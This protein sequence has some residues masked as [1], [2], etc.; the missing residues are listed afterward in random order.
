MDWQASTFFH[1]YTTHGS[2]TS[3]ASSQQT[4]EETES[5]AGKRKVRQ[6]D[7]EVG[8]LGRFGQSQLMGSTKKGFSTDWGPVGFKKSKHPLSIMVSLVYVPCS[9]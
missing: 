6:K 9:C 3:D 7:A 1:R 8:T 4:E 5:V 2:A